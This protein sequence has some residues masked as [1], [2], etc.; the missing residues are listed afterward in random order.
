MNWITDAIPGAQGSRPYC[1]RGPQNGEPLCYCRMRYVQI[2]D[3]RYV[4][5]EDLGPAPRAEICPFA[6]NECP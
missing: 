3:G 5:I 1:C 4:R 6:D 2:I